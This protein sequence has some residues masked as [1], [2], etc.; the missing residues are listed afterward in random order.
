MDFEYIHGGTVM[1]LHP[2]LQSI[3]A[4]LDIDCHI[5]SHT[6]LPLSPAL[7]SPWT[8][9]LPSYKPSGQISRAQ[10]LSELEFTLSQKERALQSNTVLLPPSKPSGQI[11]RAQ[12]LSKLEFTL[13]QKERALQLL[14]T[15]ILCVLTSFLVGCLSHFL[16][17]MG[18][19]I[20]PH[21]C[22]FSPPHGGVSHQP[23]SCLLYHQ[24]CALLPYSPHYILFSQLPSASSVHSLYMTH[25]N[26]WTLPLLA[27][28]FSEQGKSGFWSAFWEAF[29]G[30]GLSAGS[31]HLHVT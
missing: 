10:V 1:I 26:W 4:E 14:C 12:V 11:S 3:Y 7:F 24:S 22:D 5:L 25:S 28:A 15:D 29:S 18:H 17:A 16:R 19:P 13:S 30:S 2:N 27:D 31:P 6:C 23:C 9:L 21:G 20:S 8:V